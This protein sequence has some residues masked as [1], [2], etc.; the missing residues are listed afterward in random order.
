MVGSPIFG[1]NVTIVDGVYADSPSQFTDRQSYSGS[2][3]FKLPEG[4][5]ASQVNFENLPGLKDRAIHDARL[6]VPYTDMTFKH[7]EHVGSCGYMAIAA[8]LGLPSWRV[9]FEKLGFIPGPYEHL[10]SEDWLTTDRSK[11]I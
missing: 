7:V 9:V 2:A 5:D 6:S 3:W 8:A 11:Y 4:F 1:H 10:L